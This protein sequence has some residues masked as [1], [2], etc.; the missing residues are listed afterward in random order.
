MAHSSRTIDPGDPQDERVADLS[1]SAAYTYAY[2][3]L[4][5]DD[6]GRA[7]DH[8]AVFNG[9]LWPLRADTHPTSAMAD[10]LAELAAAGLVC[11]YTVDGVD[12]VHD[13]EWRRRQKLDRPMRSS[14]PRCPEHDS[15]FDDIAATLGRVPEQ[16]SSAFGSAANRIDTARL[17]SAFARVVEDVTFPV[18]PG[19]AAN[20]GQRLRDYLAGQ[21]EAS[22]TAEPS[23]EST[24]TVSREPEE[25]SRR[26]GDT[27][28]YD[29]QEPSD[30]AFGDA[31][32]PVQPPRPEG[33]D[34]PQPGTSPRN[35]WRDVTDDPNG[36]A[37][38][39]P[40]QPDDR[41]T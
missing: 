21:T 23:D 14:W 29:E 20:Y 41:D 31:E 38:S 36:G 27:W 37:W 10:D 40:P 3:P 4:A 24:V 30:D 26:S 16:L 15:P 8:A 12:Y 22:D 19:K 7:K 18:D 34:V 11:R 13:P 9:R 1:M 39:S 5:L 35:V 25:A 17:G 28:A 2:L 6:D 32:T 33:D